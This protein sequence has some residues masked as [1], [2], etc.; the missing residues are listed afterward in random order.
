MQFL[1]TDIR[2]LGATW[3]SAGTV[4]E[5]LIAHE[6]T[7]RKQKLPASTK[8][9]SYSQGDMIDA[10]LGESACR[11]LRAHVTRLGASL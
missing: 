3:V 2:T 5:A 11:G 10:S 6:N 1:I 9:S 4:R 8:V 7:W